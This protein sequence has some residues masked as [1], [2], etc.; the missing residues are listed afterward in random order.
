MWLNTEALLSLFNINRS[1]I[2]RHI[3]NIYKDKELNEDS[4]CAKI[5]YVCNDGIQVYGIKYY[6]LDIIPLI[7]ED[8]FE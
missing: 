5:A 6:N 1:K 7:D 3:N 2:V 8:E 4:T